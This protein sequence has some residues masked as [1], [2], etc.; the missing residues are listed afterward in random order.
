MNIELQDIRTADQVT[1]L[2]VAQSVDEAVFLA[3][4]NVHLSGI[5]SAALKRRAQLAGEEPGKNQ[6][7]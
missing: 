6:G 1:T 7:D 4:R 2:L 3:D 5:S